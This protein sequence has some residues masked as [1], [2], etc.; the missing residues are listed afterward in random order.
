MRA[1]VPGEGGEGEVGREG[2]WEEGERD[3]GY[4]RESESRR[5][6]GRRDA[7]YESCLFARARARAHAWGA[8]HSWF[9]D[10]LIARHGAYIRRG[11]RLLSVPCASVHAVCLAC[12]SAAC[13]IVLLLA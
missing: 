10:T 11:A 4:T 9:I 7:G 3:T 1:A 2:E 13:V 8:L 12:I 5:E 6:R